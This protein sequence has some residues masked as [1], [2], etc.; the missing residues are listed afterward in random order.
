MNSLDLEMHLQGWLVFLAASTN[1][2]ICWAA[3]DPAAPTNQLIETVAS[4]TTPING[5]RTI[6]LH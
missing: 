2:P 6:E 1:G 3:L 5:R 4:I